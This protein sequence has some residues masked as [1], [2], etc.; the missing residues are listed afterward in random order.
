V[1]LGGF[2]S[3]LYLVARLI[4]GWKA[5]RRERIGRRLLRRAVGK[6][7]GRLLGRIFR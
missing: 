1:T 2:R 6:A 4:G 3:L 5:I 7:A